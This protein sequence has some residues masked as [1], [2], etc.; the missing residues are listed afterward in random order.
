M[1]KYSKEQKIEQYG[2]GFM[3]GAGGRGLWAKKY[4]EE[5]QHGFDD[6]VIAYRAAVDKAKDRF[7]VRRTSQ[8]MEGG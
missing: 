2:S 1:P 7:K 4:P 6:G 3:D 5:Y 8:T